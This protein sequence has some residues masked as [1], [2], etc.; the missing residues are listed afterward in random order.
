[1]SRI[2]S[3][4]RNL[5]RRGRVE[6]DL[7]D[8]LRATFQLLVEENLEAGM[9]PDDA[10]RAARLELG[11]LDALKDH[12]RDVRA[13]ASMHR[14]ARDLRY[15]LRSLV[16]HPGM[17]LTLV[18]TFALGSAGVT[19]TFALVNAILLQPL[20]YPESERLVAVKHAAPGLGL[21]ETGLSSGTYFHYRDH[22]Q[23]FET[24]AVYSETVLNLSS[25]DA[26]TERVEVTYAGPELFTALKT[27]PIVGRLFTAE[28]GRPGF[29][30]MRWPIPVL[31]SHELWQRRYGG[32]EDV[33][34]GTITLNDRARR[35]VG[36]LPQGFAF[37]RAETQI[38]MLFI[39]SERTSNFARD[40]EHGAIARLRP[41]VTAAAAAAELA[42]ILPSIE[43]VYADAT[44]ARLAEVQLTP[45]VVPLREALVGDVRPLL[46]LL[47]GGMA[48]LLL[49]ACAN[50]AN[51]S[52]LRAEH[53]QREMAVR[54][55][56]GARTGDLVRLF[57]SEAALVSAAGAALGLWLADL[58]LKA[59]VLFT[60]VR[61]PRVWEV[62]LD[63]WV[64]AFT[65]SLAALG[66]LLFGGASFLRASVL[67]TP[68]S[69]RRAAAHAGRAGRRADRACAD[70][71]GRLDTDGPELLA[72]HACR[73][74]L[75]SR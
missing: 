29:M 24:L 61:L 19:A 27:R 63:V 69:G 25:P 60:P 58:A 71:A 70:A 55:A 40:L 10:R 75:R 72:A 45:I 73:R 44:A 2:I 64:L 42:R 65:C 8:E 57:V 26:G 28:D 66:T 30:D 53:R 74:G 23:T 43:G 49:V 22:A 35:V 12:V 21:A 48:V 11:S 41:G 34:G 3:F 52:L 7:D 56:L 9:A 38:W 13:G 37:P 47:F 1:M 17:S 14:L 16:K 50:T 59:I 4:W 67:T 15:A 5:L 46:L 32:A 6:R 39:P 54:T 36:V 68:D 33:I 20:P 18:I 62:D 31:L 51:L